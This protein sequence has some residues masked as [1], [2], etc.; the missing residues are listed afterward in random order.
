MIIHEMWQA[1]MPYLTPVNFR[2]K[3]LSK[4]YRSIPTNTISEIN[5][6]PCTSILWIGSARRSRV[7]ELPAGW[8][9][10]GLEPGFAEATD[11]DHA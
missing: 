5:L 4:S 11:S 2:V 3:S 6:L 7:P 1:E 8:S 9:S 10:R